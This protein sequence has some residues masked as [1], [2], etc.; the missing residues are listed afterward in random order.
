MSVHIKLIQRDGFTRRIVFHSRPTWHAL[1]AKIQSLYAIPPGNVSVVYIDA[2]SDEVTLSTQEELDDFYESS[3]QHGQVIKFIVQDLSSTRTQTKALPQTPGINI[4]DTFGG[5]GFDIEDDWQR[6]PPFSS[7]GTLFAPRDSGADSPHAFVELVESDAGTIPSQHEPNMDSESDTTVQSI[8]GDPFLVPSTK[9]KER[10]V[11]DDASSTRSVIAEHTPTK[12]AVH[13][14]DHNSS[15]KDDIVS[16]SFRLDLASSLQSVHS[17]PNA[18]SIES[19]PKVAAQDLDDLETNVVNDTRSVPNSPGDVADPPLPSFESPPAPNNPSLCSDVASFFTMLTNVMS[20]HPEL[21]ESIGNIVHNTANG[22]YLNAHRDA[23]SQAAEQL[24][25]TA[26][27][28]RRRAD[29]E[30]GRRAADALGGMLQTLSQ[31]LGTGSFQAAPAPPPEG[32]SARPP[33]EQQ[34]QPATA[35]STSFW[36][37]APQP[38]ARPFHNSHG[39]PAHHPPQPPFY[40][41]WMR[42]RPP[43]GPPRGGWRPWMPPRP[44]V[45]PPGKPPHHSDFAHEHGPPPHPP[46]PPPPPPPQFPGVWEPEVSMPLGST[47]V[48]DSSRAKP[49]P[50]E[51]KAK[52]DA[53]RL[54]YKAEKERY[55]QEREDRKKDRERKARTIGREM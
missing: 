10:V 9:G 36:Y 14:F 15:D 29:E 18:V 26:E 25:Q 1:A 43:F 49:T 5:E 28:I 27:E 20:A 54:R 11:A 3:Y 32:D 39:S 48:N 51:S 55:R 35:N 42:G 7:L 30:A 46:A 44:P 24:A 52:V 23:I 38:N 34:E 53:A 22:T 2:E 8:A 19:T 16:S 6:L 12:P 37:G 33:A 13:V 45:P 40:N 4:R 17:P 47:P 21:A 50:E 41:P 31:T